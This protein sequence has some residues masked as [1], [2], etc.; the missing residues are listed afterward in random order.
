ME[1]NAKGKTRQY[2]AMI[3]GML[4]A[5]VKLLSQPETAEAA[6]RQH[7]K[8]LNIR[9]DVYDK[10]LYSTI[11]RICGEQGGQ[12]FL[13]S[14]K[15]ARL[16]SMSAGKVSSGKQKLQAAGL[17]AITSRKRS[18]RGHAMDHITVIDIWKRNT[19]IMEKRKSV[20]LMNRSPHEPKRSPHERNR[21]PH[22]TEEELMKENHEEDY[23]LLKITNEPQQAV[24]TPLAESTRQELQQTASSSLQGENH[25]P[26]EDPSAEND[27]KKQQEAADSA[28]AKADIGPADAS[29][30]DTNIEPEFNIT[31][32]QPELKPWDVVRL[33]ER[34][35]TKAGYPKTFTGSREKKAFRLAKTLLADCKEAGV[36]VRAVLLEHIKD[37]WEAEN[38]LEISR[39]VARFDDL[40]TTIRQSPAQ[41]AEDEADAWD[42]FKDEKTSV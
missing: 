20:H 29:P 35:W 17:I 10:W 24:S 28:L 22:D 11:R 1:G 16:A 15:L 21:S 38:N 31:F 39:V 6:L 7:E 26:A 34:L 8:E 14:K 13:S 19:D 23:S 27:D 40:V 2:F 18:A 37:K 32:E 42:N 4:W 3:P 5:D 41:S 9:L 33:A 25:P 12:C 36:T 30:P